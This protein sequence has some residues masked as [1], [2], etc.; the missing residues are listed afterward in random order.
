[1]SDTRGPSQQSSQ[2]PGERL[3]DPVEVARAD[4]PAEAAS[5]PQRGWAPPRAGR[6]V[7]LLAAGFVLAG[8]VLVLY[9]WGLPPFASAIQTSVN[10]YVR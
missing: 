5:A 1:M 9:A 4:E 6:K 3:A 10:A 7:T 2:Q 8:I